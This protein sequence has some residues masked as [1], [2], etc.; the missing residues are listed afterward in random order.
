MESKRGRKAANFSANSVK[1]AQQK[2]SELGKTAAETLSKTGAIQA[3]KKQIM[4]ARARGVA[5]ADIAAAMAES[6]VTVSPRSLK[7]EIEAL[8]GAKPAKKKET[9]Q[10]QQQKKP[11]AA[12]KSSVNFAS[13]A[14][15]EI[16]P[17]RGD[18]L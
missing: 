9:K 17:D 16:P 5:W 10:Q 13:G 11:V 18:E 8:G 2:V 12:P 1:I 3:M 14:G 4:S 7:S 15:F 6:G